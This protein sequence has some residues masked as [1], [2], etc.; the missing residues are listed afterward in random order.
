MPEGI[1][2]NHEEIIRLL[3]SGKFEDLIGVFENERLECKQQPY[4]LESDK[5][6]VEFSKDV[7]AMA[8][9]DGGVILLGYRTEK[10]QDHADDKIVSFRPLP[11]EKIDTAKMKA[12]LSDR[13][14]PNIDI[15]IR[16]YKANENSCAVSIRVRKAAAGELPILVRKPLLDD[17]AQ[18]GYLFG[19][20]ERKLAHTTNFP[21]DRFHALLRRG[22]TESTINLALESLQSQIAALDRSASPSQTAKHADGCDYGASSPSATMP[23]PDVYEGL[24][25]IID[26]AVRDAGLADEP[27]FT[28]AAQPIP[29]INLLELF[30]GRGSKLVSLIN[31]PPEIRVGGFDLDLGGN[32]RIVEGLKRVTVAE[33]YGICE[34]YKSGIIIYSF[35]ADQEGLSWGRR[36]QQRESLL[37]NQ[38]TLA[39]KI[40]LFAKFVSSVYVDYVRGGVVSFLVQLERTS[41]NGKTPRLEGGS[42]GDFPRTSK[43]APA[44]YFY[45]SVEISASEITRPAHIAEEILKLIYNWFGFDNSQIPYLVDKI[46]GGGIDVESLQSRG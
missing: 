29:A 25:H 41:V 32:S 17:K 9:A 33:N 4:D 30:D 3:E 45:K 42:L 40:Y 37:I 2:I 21:I 23:N 38:L 16:V 26:K 15:D 28:L 44:E 18:S 10:Q 22:M 31:S 12:I 27:T 14:Y 6:K 34:V 13:L 35:K 46:N 1:I 19:L 24:Q 39:E 7:S 5:N 20:F 36:E 8:N 11:L 43:S